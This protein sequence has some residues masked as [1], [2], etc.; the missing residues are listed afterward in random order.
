MPNHN[1]TAKVAPKDRL[2]SRPDQ[3]PLAT[4]QDPQAP[5][6]DPADPKVIPTQ[7]QGSDPKADDIDYTA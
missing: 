7:G 4:P 1:P 6:G 3:E 5:R 2:T